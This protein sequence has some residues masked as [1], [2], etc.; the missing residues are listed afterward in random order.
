[1]WAFEN[2]ENLA[3]ITDVLSEKVGSDIKSVPR[4]EEDSL[5]KQELKILILEWLYVKHTLFPD[6]STWLEIDGCTEPG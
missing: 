2:Y 4:K 1:M 3:C 5:L 6:A